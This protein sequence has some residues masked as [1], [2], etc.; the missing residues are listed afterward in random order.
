[1]PSNPNEPR[2]GNHFSGGGQSNNNAHKAPN[3]A[4]PSETAEFM[5]A[6]FASSPRN[7]QTQQPRT[8]QSDR[9][10]EN[11]Q[12]VNTAAPQEPARITTRRIN[13]SESASYRQRSPQKNRR[14]GKTAAAV[15][16]AVVALVVIISGICGFTMYLDYKDITARV[17]ALTEQAHTLVD[18]AKEADGDTLRNTAAGIA[19]E[20]SDI[21]GKLEGIPWQIASFIPVLGQDVRSVRTVVDQA[22]NLCQYALIPACDDLGN[23]KL[24]NLLEDGVINVDLFT[25]LA[26]TLSQVAPVVQQSAETIED[27]PEPVIDRL[28]EPIQ[29]VKDLMGTADEAVTKL[30]EMAPYL[31]EMLGANGETRNYL[32]IAQSNAELRSTGGFPGA[33]GVMTVVN[34]SINLGDFSSFASMDWYDTPGFGVTEEELT[35]F[36]DGAGNDNRIGR[37]PAD[38]N[39]IPDFARACEIISAIWTDQHGGTIDGIIAIDPVFL[40]NML[41]L[42]GGFTTSSGIA[43]DGT[44]AAALLLH[45]AYNTFSTSDQDQF[46]AEVAGNAF[47]QLTS[48]LGGMGFTDLLN[49]ITTGIDESRLQ[50]WMADS[51]EETLMVEMGCDGTIP[52]DPANPE[53][54]VYVSDD[55]YSKIAWYLSLHTTIN[56]STKNMDGT[57]TYNV[58]TTLT[59]NLDPYDAYNQ[60]DYITG[61]NTAKRNRSDMIDKVYLFAPAGGTI[62][63]VYVDGYVPEEFPLKEGTYNGRQVWY[64]TLQTSGLETSTLTYNVT[65]SADAAELAIHQ[66]PTAQS[67]A[68]WQ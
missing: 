29:K 41:A 54:G 68:G 13:S 24:S 35:I 61:S 23:I 65:T 36:G 56:S 7:A 9:A 63:D 34:G 4:R 16:G 18:A 26:N 49:A 66:T 11:A 10:A 43:V 15:I 48:S 53:L 42:T 64:V 27:L 33:A 31:P 57:T 58:T 21:H 38:T 28:R 50:V 46:F 2:R 45:D 32:I 39:I 30:N 52:N 22:D 67:V 8:A 25:S 37:I 59:N 6:Y 51:D 55:T 3:T 14:N 62:S 17:P 19:T 1:M 40:Q 12:R 44:N 20:V 47:S 5:S 60:V